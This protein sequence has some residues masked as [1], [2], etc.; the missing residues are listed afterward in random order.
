VERSIGN[1]NPTIWWR[2]L[3]TLK[4]DVELNGLKNVDMV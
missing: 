2:G 3:I 1:E 4:A